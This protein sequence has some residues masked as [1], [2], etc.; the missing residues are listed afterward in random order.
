MR[1]LSA[2]K[3]ICLPAGL[4]KEEVKRFVEKEYKVRAT[5]DCADEIV[6]ILEAE[7]KK[8]ADFAVKK[9]KTDNRMTIRKDDVAEYVARFGSD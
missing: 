4:S 1:I 6:K 5:D 2:E 8:I 3:G 7:A 9:A